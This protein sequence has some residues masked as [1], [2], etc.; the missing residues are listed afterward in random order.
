MGNR[1]SVWEFMAGKMGVKF[2]KIVNVNFSKKG[3]NK[4]PPAV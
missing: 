4:L 1:Y 2:W 3:A